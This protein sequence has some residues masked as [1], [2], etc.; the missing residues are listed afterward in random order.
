MSPAECLFDAGGILS[1]FPV[2]FGIGVMSFVVGFGCLHHPFGLARPQQFVVFYGSILA[3]IF[4]LSAIEY[5]VENFRQSFKWTNLLKLA[6]PAV[7]LVGVDL[8]LLA[9]HL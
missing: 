5:A 1:L 4:A 7:A 2:W 8:L 3:I 9:S 6:V